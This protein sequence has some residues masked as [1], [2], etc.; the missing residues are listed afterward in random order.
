MLSVPAS[1]FSTLIYKF[2]PGHGSGTVPAGLPQGETEGFYKYY[3]IFTEYNNIDQNQ[4]IRTKQQQ[5]ISSNQQQ[6]NSSKQYQK[7]R[8]K[9][10]KKKQ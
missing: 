5:K 3:K 9:Q 6:K 10:Q 4:K 2:G 1:I 8:S 7:S